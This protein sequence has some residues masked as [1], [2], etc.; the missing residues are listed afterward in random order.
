MSSV[1]NRAYS[2][3]LMRCSPVFAAVMSAR[4]AFRNAIVLNISFS[5]ILCAVSAQR[6]VVGIQPS[7]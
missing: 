4:K 1:S 3:K 2:F 5:D 7:R 6:D